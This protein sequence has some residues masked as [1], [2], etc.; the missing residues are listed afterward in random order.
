MAVLLAIVLVTFSMP[1]GGQ[2]GGAG[3]TPP[4]PPR[5]AAPIDL[6]G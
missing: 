6:T 2:R 1:A 4:V 5:G 3:P